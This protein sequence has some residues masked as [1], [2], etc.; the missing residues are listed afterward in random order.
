MS[1][2]TVTKRPARLSS[3]V[4]VAAAAVAVALAV[5]VAA[6]QLP[7]AVELAGLAVAAL[8][9]SVAARGYRTAGVAVGVAG[10]ALALASVPVAVATTG[11]TSVRLALV[12][13]LVGLF[14]LTLAVLPVRG[15][16]SRW[17]VKLGSGL[18]FV[19]VLAATLFRL[20]PSNVLLAGAVLSVLAWDAGDNA[21]GIGEQLGTRAAT[22]RPELVHLCGTAAVGVVG[23]GATFAV[24]GV[25]VAGFSLE[26]FV[27][28]LGAVVLLTLALHG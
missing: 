13:G 28:L 23:V 10:S 18:V 11:E 7:L 4:G 15:S 2:V 25:A 21:I 16:G 6:A 3:A 9:A 8:G 19:C 5:G 27:L 20:S 26:S 17:L 12:P 14:A 24:D 22:R 1:A